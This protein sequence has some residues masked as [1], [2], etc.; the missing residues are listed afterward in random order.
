M[1]LTAAQEL[2]WRLMGLEPWIADGGREDRVLVVRHDVDQHP[3]TAVRMARID[4]RHGVR[5]TWYFRWRTTSLDR[6]DVVRGLGGAIGFHYETLTRLALERGLKADE[7]DP[8]LIEEAREQLR[9]EIEAFQAYVGPIRSICAHGDTR[10]PGVSNQVLVQGQAPASLGIEFDANEALSRH[11]LALWMTDRAASEGGWK[12]GIDPL[13]VLNESDGPVLCLTHPNNWCSGVS[14]WSDRLRSALLPEPSITRRR[15]LLG[16]RTGRD[17]PRELSPPRTDGD[18]ASQGRPPGTPSLAGPPDTAAAS[19][20]SE[21]G[22]NALVRQVERAVTEA[23]HLEVSD[24]SLIAVGAADELT[25]LLRSRGAQVTSLSEVVPSERFD[26]VLLGGAPAMEPAHTFS[27][28]RRLARLG[29]V[30]LA[31]GPGDEAVPL[32]A[33]AVLRR[34][35]RRAGFVE[36]RGVGHFIVAKRPGATPAFRN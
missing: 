2:G 6:I 30:L 21:A 25:S 23:I 5:G 24:C 12:E 13:T 35:L 10:V 4:A 28:L 1:L 8:P 36:I 9:I 15:H 20:E 14:L 33:A 11:R 22:S 29:G 32:G 31:W 3:D 34:R 26:V 18:A 7:L 19:W 17:R 27:D 16:T